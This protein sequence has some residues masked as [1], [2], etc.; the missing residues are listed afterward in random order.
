[1]SRV[2][3]G[4]ERAFI[5]EVAALLRQPGSRRRIRIEGE[6]FDLAVPT[7]RVPDGATVV[8][9]GVL[10]AVSEGI[11]VSGKVVTPWEGTCRRCL[12]PAFGVVEDEFRELYCEDGDP[13]TTY[14]MRGDLLDLAPVVRDA[15]ILD[16]PLA[17][18]CRA[19]CAGLCP[20]CGINRNFEQCS[21]GAPL[22][23][24]WA[25]LRALSPEV[26]DGPETGSH[27][28]E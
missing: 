5:V 16:L 28:S 13:E 1:M 21:C 25:G 23:P 3:R 18:L 15:C 22:D 27:P 12:E 8:F 24:R 19:D 14:P 26:V 7:A 9:D 11:L 2:P 6:L 20:E 10:E 17:P 4:H